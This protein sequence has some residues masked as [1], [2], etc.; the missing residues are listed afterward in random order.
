[1]WREVH[2]LG[3]WPQ[4]VR[5]LQPAPRRTGSEAGKGRPDAGTES[6]DVWAR[7]GS[8]GSCRAVTTRTI[9]NVYR[10]GVDQDASGAAASAPVT[11]VVDR[12]M[13]QAEADKFLGRVQERRHRCAS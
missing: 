5:L 1:M 3:G 6:T 10:D 11:I 4:L 8:R 7:A 9:R 2:Y 12:K 13:P